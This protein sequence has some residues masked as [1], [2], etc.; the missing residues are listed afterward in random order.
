VQHSLTHLY[1]FYRESSLKAPYF[2]IVVFITY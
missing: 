1:S 2:T